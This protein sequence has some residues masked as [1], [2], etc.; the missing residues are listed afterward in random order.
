MSWTTKLLVI[1]NRTVE[2][3]EIRD[4]IVDRATAG[5][6]QVTLVAPAS[7]GTGSVRARRMETAQRLERAVQQ[8]TDAGVPVEGVVGD[9]DPLVAVQDVWDPRRFDEV[10]VVTLP[11]GVSRWMAADLPHRVERLTAA[12]VT[13]VVAAAQPAASASPSRAPAARRS[14]DVAVALASAGS[15]PRRTARALVRRP[16]RSG[17]PRGGRSILH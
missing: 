16:R 1:A 14:P 3:A 6:V 11:T 8:L 10:V 5:P 4:V 17:S 7:S 2:S 15:S 9:T 13:H 12:R